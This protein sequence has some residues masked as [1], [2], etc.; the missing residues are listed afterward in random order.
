MNFARH[1]ERERERDPS[2]LSVL[3]LSVYFFCTLSE[4][5]GGRASHPQ[6]SYC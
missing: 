1:S 4:R 5:E 3:C 6:G 2:I